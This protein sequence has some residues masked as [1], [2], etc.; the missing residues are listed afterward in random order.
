MTELNKLIWTKTFKVFNI[1]ISLFHQNNIYEVVN[2]FF[3]ED[4]FNCKTNLTFQSRLFDN[5]E[6][7]VNYINSFI[8]KRKDYMEKSI[9]LLV[10]HQNKNVRLE[11]NK[12]TIS[13]GVNC[14][15]VLKPF[16][17]K[18]LFSGIPKNKVALIDIIKNIDDVKDI[19]DFADFL[20]KQGKLK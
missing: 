15:E 18:N 3:K 7:S 2:I 11:R 20:F 1:T 13:V 12:K 16:R 9:K 6:N 17:Q 14:Q 4:N 10:S 8:Q 5:K 19:K